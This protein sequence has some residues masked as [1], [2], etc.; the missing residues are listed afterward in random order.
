MTIKPGA[1]V[2]LQA[3]ALGYT[4]GV[5]VSAVYVNG[6]MIDSAVSD[7]D[8]YITSFYSTGGTI[9]STGG[10]TYHFS[11]G[12]GVTTYA[13]TAT[14]LISAGITIRDGGTMPFNVAPGTTASGIDLLVSG[15]I[16]NLHT[17]NNPSNVESLSKTGSGLLVLSGS[18]TYNGTTTIS[19]GTLQIGNGG[20]GEYLG[21]P[22]VTLSNGA[23][24][25]FDHADGL[26]Y[27]GAIG[28]VGSLT[29]TGTGT[30]TL[31]AINNYSGVTNINAGVLSL[32]N[33]AA[34]AGG[35][36]ITF[37][38]G[39]LQYSAANTQD[40]SSRI[41]GS[42]GPVSI[43][44]NG[45]NIGFGSTLASSNSAGLTKL[46]TGTLTLAASQNYSGGTIVS[47]G[48]LKLG[49]GAAGVPISGVTAVS[50]GG[51]NDYASALQRGRLADQPHEHRHA[52]QGRNLK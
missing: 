48:V 41:V 18:N 26:T 49:T 31:S 37:G 4:G 21:S 38:G 19:A 15:N 5:A 20:S 43:D 33:G 25:A 46:G 16:G 29:K 3:N 14:S 23:A 30:L 10:G 28:G 7:N 39:T 51:S 8:A 45:Q 47:G 35:G 11:N 22:V 34:L 24:L 42:T 27:A 50:G 2:E 40:Y 6:A 44:T 12:F 17:Y 1:D 36:N 9:S 52:Q 32:A 13:S